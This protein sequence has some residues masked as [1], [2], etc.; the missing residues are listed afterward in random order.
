MPSIE[1]LAKPAPIGGRQYCPD[2][3]TAILL[4]KVLKD[5]SIHGRI[6]NIRYSPVVTLYEFEPSAG[7][8]SSSDRV[9]PM[10]LLV[11]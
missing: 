4:N 7:T 11:Q 2:D 9:Y 3:S 8:K 10:I 6:V 1:Y 5:F